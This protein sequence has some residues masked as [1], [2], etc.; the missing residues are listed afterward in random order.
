[1]ESAIDQCTVL[2]DPAIAMT[3]YEVKLVNGRGLVATLQVA[4]EQ[5]ILDA[6]VAS[7]LELPSLCRLGNCPS[8]I[9]VLVEGEID[10]SAQSY[11]A[12]AELQLGLILLCVARP[13][14]DCTIK[15]HLIN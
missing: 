5:Y 15:T 10:Q 11:L 6:A 12:A 14:S 9:S 8:C 7:G 1:M 4:R 13:R 2:E 3:M